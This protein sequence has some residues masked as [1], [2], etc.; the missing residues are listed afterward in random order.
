M[1]L[2][3]YYNI[4]INKYLCSYNLSY[5]CAYW[6]KYFLAIGTLLTSIEL[7]PTLS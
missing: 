1:H 3:G 5:H 6:Y 2:T 7:W 4:L